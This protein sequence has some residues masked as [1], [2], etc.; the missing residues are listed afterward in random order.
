[1]KKIISTALSIIFIFS[2]TISGYASDINYS[3]YEEYLGYIEQGILSEE[4]SYS[5]WMN[6]IN[7]NERLEAMLEES[8][9]FEL[10]YSSTDPS[11]NSAF[12]MRY[13]DIYITNATSSAGLTGHAGIAMNDISIIHIRGY[14]HR[15]STISHTSWLELYSGGW[16]KVY[17]HTNSDAAWQAAGWAR[18]NYYN[19]NAEYAI[20]LD[21]TVTN[22]TYC[23]KIV[24]QSY[25][26][27]RPG[28][29]AD[30]PAN[31]AVILPYDLPN[32]ITPNT[33]VY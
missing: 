24:W 25:Y 12:T 23:S 17:R 16:T 18:T 6:L 19:S 4:I 2:F 21:P 27:I 13:G 31:G 32:L 10:V 7:E 33:Q 9:Q 1:M 26:F 14:G 30:P 29:Y 5:T 15:V 11:R 8:D 3:R 20:S 22:P 28:A